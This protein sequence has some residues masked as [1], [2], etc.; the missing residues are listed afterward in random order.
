MVFQSYALYPH[1]TVFENMA[2]ALKL[3]KLPKA[4]IADKVRG[5][6][7]VLGIGSELSK[8]PKQLSG[9]QRQRVALGRAIVREPQCF[10]FDEPLSNLDAKLRV[11]MRAEI[12]RLH[13][14]A[15]QHDRL[16][17]A[18]SGRG[19]HTRRS[20]GRHEGRGRAAV[21]ERAG[22]LPP[23]GEP[24]RGGL[25]GHAAHELLRRAPG[26]RGRPAVVRRGDRQAAGPGADSG[27]AARARGGGQPGS[28]WA[29]VP[30]RWRRRQRRASRRRARSWR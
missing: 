16:R 10:L 20:R 19:D 23:P 25:P 6:A 1:M 29:C 7:D 27:G 28:C 21:R 30:R 17:H 26:R 14:R 13:L 15:R 4:T 22:H 2:F 24:V 11:E 9:G 3:R 12:K 18:R 5:A 8:R